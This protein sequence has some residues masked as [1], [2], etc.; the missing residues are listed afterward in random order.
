MRLPAC[1]ALLAGVGIALMSGGRRP[2][3]GRARAAARAGLLVRGLLICAIGLA[4]AYTQPDLEIIL[5][6]FGLY[7]IFA[8]PLLGLRPS[9]LWKVALGI[10]LLIGAAVASR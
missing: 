3:E 6:F 5:A 8:I 2:L 7:F 9:V 4:L 1:F 10:A